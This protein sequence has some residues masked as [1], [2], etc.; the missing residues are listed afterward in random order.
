MLNDCWKMYPE[1]SNRLTTLG[2]NCDF[3]D[4]DKWLPSSGDIS[5]YFKC[6]WNFCNCGMTLETAQSS[7]ELVLFEW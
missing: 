2:T 5:N 1:L 3:D 6:M 7:F 4:F